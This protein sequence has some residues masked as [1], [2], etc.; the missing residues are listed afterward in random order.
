MLQIS[1]E[2]FALG[3]YQYLR[4]P[5]EYFLDTA[6]LLGMQNVELWA[7][8][9]SF[10]LDTMDEAQMKEKAAQI[11]SREISVCCITPEQCQYPVNLAA[12]DEKIR[13]YSIRNFERCI[14]CSRNI[15]LPEGVG[16]SWMR[17]FQQTSGGCVEAERREPVSFV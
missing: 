17:L 13:E 16:F 6:V 10:C 14:L 9:P 12:E 8:G 5:F 11:R 4:Y 15:E 2:R 1:K 3:S 7:A